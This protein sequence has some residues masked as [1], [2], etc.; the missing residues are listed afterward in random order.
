MT[1]T[2]TNSGAFLTDLAPTAIALASYF[3]FSDLVLISQCSYYNWINAQPEYQQARRR[4]SIE[5]DTTAVAD[6]TEDEPLLAGQRQRRNSTGLPGSHRRHSIHH[7]DS[8]LAPLVR[9]VTGED[10][11]PD[12][13]PWLHNALSL[14]VVWIV[15]ITAWFL[16]YK[17]GAYDGGSAGADKPE[18]P[19]PTHAMLGM[20]LG[21][22]SAM[23]YLT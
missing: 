1:N 19:A 11:T 7:N 22:C 18:A 17:S 5:T 10:D 2:S 8:N 13:D 3:C 12:N 21:Y 23:C 16:Y 4:Q 9:V 15:G 6:A 20:V 14:L